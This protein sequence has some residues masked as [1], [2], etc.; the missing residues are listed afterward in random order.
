MYN[1]V[2]PILVLSRFGLGFTRFS[3]VESFNLYDV[4]KVFTQQMLE[5]DLHDAS[6]KFQIFSNHNKF[7]NF[8]N[9]EKIF[10]LVRINTY[11][12]LPLKGVL[13][14]DKNHVSLSLSTN[15]QQVNHSPG[16]VGSMDTETKQ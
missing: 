15:E 12:N 10:I 3:N 6:E 13:G 2:S 16:L 4:I 1:C 11:K 8:R 14:R 7:Q 9:C 5:K